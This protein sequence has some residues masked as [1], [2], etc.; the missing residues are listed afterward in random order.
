MQ[1]VL[2]L[3]FFAS[4]IVPASALSIKMYLANPHLLLHFSANSI[5]LGITSDG[6]NGISLSLL[7]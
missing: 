3:Y 4:A 7:L 1:P 2:R 6:A 5:N